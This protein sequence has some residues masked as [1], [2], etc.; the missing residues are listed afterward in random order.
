M[1]II[2]KDNIDDIIKSLKHAQRKQVP[3]AVAGALTATAFDAQRAIK[4]NLAKKFTLR[5]RFTLSGVRVKKANKRTLMARVYFTPQTARYMARQEF[6]ATIT[7]S[8]NSIAV[9][10]GVRKDSSKRVT[11]AKR[12]RRILE[13]ADTFRVVGRPEIPDGI[14]QRKKNGRLKML[15]ALE[16]RVRIRPR[17]GFEKTVAGVAKNKIRGHFKRSQ[18]RALA[19]AR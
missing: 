4:A 18:S 14:Y 15:Y 19:T 13:R 3:F 12:P 8:G 5:N 11:P 17:F 1:Q 16:N 2:V 6:G 9:P 10:M 7:P